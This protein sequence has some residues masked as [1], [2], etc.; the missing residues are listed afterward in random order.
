MV[1]ETNI[2]T[3][4]PAI[5]LIRLISTPFFQL[6]RQNNLA[7]TL[8]FSLFNI[9]GNSI[10]Y[11]IKIYSESTT[12]HPFTVN[13]AT[14]T[15]LAY[16]NN[17]LATLHV[18]ALVSCLSG[19]QNASFMKEEILFVLFPAASPGRR[20]VYRTFLSEWI[21]CPELGCMPIPQPVMGKWAKIISRPACPFLDL[22]QHQ[23]PLRLR[24]EWGKDGYV[25]KM[26]FR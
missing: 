19:Y 22:W 13:T 25:N 24:I 4:P 26:S 6:F 23:L 8:D 3:I 11:T 5:W 17:L 14:I 20:T 15:C 12:S 7:I 9:L 1:R 10:N 18:S 21:N 2:Q 16:C